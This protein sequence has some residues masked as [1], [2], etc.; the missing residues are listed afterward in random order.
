MEQLYYNKPVLEKISEFIK[1]AMWIFLLVLAAS[2]S[3]DKISAI[4]MILAI[5]IASK[6]LIKKYNEQLAEYNPKG[7]GW[8]KISVKNLAFTG[9]IILC[10]VIFYILW[11]KIVEAKYV[12]I[13]K[14]ANYKLPKPITYF[15]RTRI[16][17]PIVEELIFRGIFFN[18]F[19]NINDKKNNILAILVSSAVFTLIH[20]YGINL[21]VLIYFPMSLFFAV[22]SAYTKDLKYPM[23]LHFFINSFEGYIRFLAYKI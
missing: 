3:N 10:Y 19:F 17:S 20:T 2:P 6:F 7:F 12:D 16:G 9:F 23:H 5:Y 14:M 4:F 1:D 11:I 13:S 15:I 18:L 22:I 8:K 21:S